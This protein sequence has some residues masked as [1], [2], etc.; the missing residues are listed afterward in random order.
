LKHWYFLSGVDVAAAARASSIVILGDSITDGHTASVNANDRWTDRLASRLQDLPAAKSR[1]VL[2]EGIG[3]NRLLLDGLGPN[4]MARFDRDVLSQS[5]IGYLIIFEGIN[6]IGT[7][8]HDG[9]VSRADHDAFVAHILSAYSQMIVRA[10]DHGVKVIGATLM[11]Y[12]GTPYYANSAASEVDRQAINQWIRAPGH[13]DAVIDF[14][15]VLRDLIHPEHILAAYDSGDH[16]HPSP[17]G[18]LV[19]GDAVPL[20]IFSR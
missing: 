10:H 13:F 20:E 1:G 8:T 11:P 14:D 2:N 19:M 9:E 12:A 18:Y 3:G 6:D 7:L 15:Q 5:G 17:K 4:A 16:I